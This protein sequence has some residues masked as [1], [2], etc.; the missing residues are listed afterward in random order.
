MLLNLSI[1]LFHFG[2]K[3]VSFKEVESSFLV[4]LFISILPDDLCLLSGVFSVS[5]L[6]FVPLA[7]PL[8]LILICQD[9]LLLHCVS[10]FVIIVPI[11][12]N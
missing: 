2:V 7:L 8:C 9:F 10:S 1:V 6:F 4:G 3:C 5:H 12:F 11:P